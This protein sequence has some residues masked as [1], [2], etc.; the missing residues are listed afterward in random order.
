M[1]TIKKVKPFERALSYSRELQ[2][3]RYRFFE[4]DQL[5]VDSMPRNDRVTLTREKFLQFA[6]QYNI[7]IELLS[8]A[9]K[10]PCEELCMLS[11]LNN[12]ALQGDTE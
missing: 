3:F 5:P 8:L 12:V 11:V 9:T 6:T 4:G 2:E 10:L 1:N 7:M